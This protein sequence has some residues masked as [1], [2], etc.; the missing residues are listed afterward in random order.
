[1]TSTASLI[2][3]QVQLVHFALDS[4]QRIHH[5]SGNRAFGRSDAFAHFRQYFLGL[6]ELAP[7]M[8]HTADDSDVLAIHSTYLARAT[9]AMVIAPLEAV[10]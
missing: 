8:V 10:E 7:G 4:V 5:G 2:I 6:H 1:M 3:S 9:I